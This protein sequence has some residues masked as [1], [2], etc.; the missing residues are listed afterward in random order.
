MHSATVGIC[1]RVF[2]SNQKTSSKPIKESFTPL[3]Y[4][5]LSFPEY[6]SSL[7]SPPSINHKHLKLSRLTDHPHIHALVREHPL[8]L[9]RY[10]RPSTH[11]NTSLHRTNNNLLAIHPPILQPSHPTQTTLSIR[12]SR[13]P[14]GLPHIHPPHPPTRCQPIRSRR[15]PNPKP[16]LHLSRR[17]IRPNASGDRE[18]V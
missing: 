6:L 8:H 16:S 3:L 18:G 12:L 5:R 4:V 11:L 2:D 1:K 9:L 17:R 10:D 7:S 15:I 13:Y 14:S